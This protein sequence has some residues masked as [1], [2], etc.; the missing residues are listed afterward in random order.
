M[1][2]NTNTANNL[3]SVDELVCGDAHIELVGE[4]FHI[5]LYKWTSAKANDLTGKVYLF[6]GGVSNTQQGAR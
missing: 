1:W 2:C 6:H 5:Y 4:C 3:S